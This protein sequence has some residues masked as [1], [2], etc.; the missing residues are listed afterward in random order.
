M[1]PM[2]L[3]CSDS[4]IICGPVSMTGGGEG[5]GKGWAGP[6]MY[7]GFSENNPNQIIMVMEFKMRTINSENVRKCSIQW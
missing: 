5:L 6:R 4:Y 1:H 3:L 2:D 7:W